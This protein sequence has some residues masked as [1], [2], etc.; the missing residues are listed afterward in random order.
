MASMALDAWLRRRRRVVFRPELMALSTFASG[1][2]W[3]ARYGTARP[4]VLALHGW[5]RDHHDFDDVLSGFD[6][7]ALDLPGHGV[8]PEP[9]EAW[10]TR[11]YAEWVAPVLHDLG[12]GPWVVLGHS[13]GA[14]VAVHLADAEAAP[15]YGTQIAAL[16]LTG[17]PLAPPPGMRP[18]RPSFAY[19][20]GRALHR[21][22]LVSDDRIEQLRR[23]HGSDEYRRASPVMRGV[24]VKAVGETAG[25]AYIPPLRQWAAGGGA[26]ELV[27]WERD[28]EASLDGV[29][30]GLDGV[31][32]GLDGV[33]T[34]LDGLT[35]PRATVVPGSG[36]LL[37]REMVGE[38]QAALL[39]HQPAG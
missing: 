22:G 29:L 16:V 28:P 20:T 24:L 5:G 9:P 25:A 15:Q 31:L 37:N 12:G 19:R 32:T 13:F 11:Q 35:S 14:R 1:R 6:A 38:V 27:W 33:P 36:H 7:V 3:G 23:R 21:A 34:G 18:P 10:S 26:L 17:A 4:W 39:R 8:A 30:K 2:L